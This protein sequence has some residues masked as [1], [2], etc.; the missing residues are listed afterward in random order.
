MR[1]EHDA[2]EPAVPKASG[3]ERAAQAASSYP[4][5]GTSGT[6]TAPRERL[7]EPG[8]AA[9][10]SDSGSGRGGGDGGYPNVGSTGLE[11]APKERI[12]VR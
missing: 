7:R 9:D 8:S 10:R 6:G 5:V 3:R 1:Q 11:T 4:N 2:E 12:Y